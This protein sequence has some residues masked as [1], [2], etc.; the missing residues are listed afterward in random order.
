MKAQWISEQAFVTQLQV[1]W[2]QAEE[3]VEQAKEHL[4]RLRSHADIVTNQLHQAKT[5]LNATEDSLRLFVD[6]HPQD[7]G[8]IALAGRLSFL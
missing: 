7:P 3:L 2:V 1:T 6:L 8:M 5:S 4:A